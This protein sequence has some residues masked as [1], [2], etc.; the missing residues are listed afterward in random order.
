MPVTDDVAMA[1][2][3]LGLELWPADIPFPLSDAECALVCRG[4][5][6]RWPGTAETALQLPGRYELLDKRLSVKR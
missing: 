5:P 4:H 3:K 2:E 6:V 1:A